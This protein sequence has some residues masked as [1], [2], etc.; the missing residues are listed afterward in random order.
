MVWGGRAVA[1]AAMVGYEAAAASVGRLLA[2]SISLL[3]HEAGA[4]SPPRTSYFDAA[5]PRQAAFEPMTLHQFLARSELV[6]R[7]ER[8]VFRRHEKTVIGDLREVAERLAPGRACIPVVLDDG[9]AKTGGLLNLFPAFRKARLPGSGSAGVAA[10]ALARCAKFFAGEV[11]HNGVSNPFILLAVHDDCPGFHVFRR[12][13]GWTSRNNRRRFRR[14]EFQVPFGRIAA[15]IAPALHDAWQAGAQRGGPCHKRRSDSSRHRR[16]GKP[17]LAA[18]FCGRI[19]WTGP[20]S[21]RHAILH[22]SSGRH[23]TREI[24]EAERWNARALPAV[25]LRRHGGGTLPAAHGRA[26]GESPAA[27]FWHV[28]GLHAFSCVGRKVSRFH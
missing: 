14:Q 24:V 17:I 8:G 13:A 27:S 4:A 18:R 12:P 9:F 22:Y 25:R 10:G 2:D 21:R 1:V 7:R 15:R 26:W 23:R 3:G 16:R 6:S 20:T 5:F 11:F 19:V 28:D